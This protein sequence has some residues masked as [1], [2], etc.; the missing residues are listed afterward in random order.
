MRSTAAVAK[1]EMGRP[2]L[3]PAGAESVRTVCHLTTVEQA[4]LSAVAK[5]REMS[6]SGLLRSM[7]LDLLAIE[8]QS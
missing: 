3:D 8:G 6:V 2:T 7:V 1:S 5:Q 4:G